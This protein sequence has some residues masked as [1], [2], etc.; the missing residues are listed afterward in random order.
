MEGGRLNAA[1]RLVWDVYSL[2]CVLFIAVIIVNLLLVWGIGYAD[3]VTLYVNNLGE[4]VQEQLEIL[5]LVP[6]VT[7][8]FF[9][10]IEDTARPG[11]KHVRVTAEERSALRKWLAE[12]RRQKEKG[13]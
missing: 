12:K 3:G 4:G 11:R 1:A 2:V 9:R 10:T 7:V 8:T 6:W 13:P 5:S